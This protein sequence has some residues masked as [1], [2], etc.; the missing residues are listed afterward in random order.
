LC[1]PVGEVGDRQRLRQDAQVM[2]MAAPLRHRA[3][4][5]CGW[6]ARRRLLLGVAK[7]D[8]WTH[9]AETGH[10]PAVPLVIRTGNAAGIPQPAWQ[11]QS[12]GGCH[13]SDCWY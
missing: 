1:Y 4:C 8:A 9:S 2:V 12:E 7:V 3:W 13:R 11:R 5:S 6:S 10:M